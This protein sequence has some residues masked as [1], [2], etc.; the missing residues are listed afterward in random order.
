M[1]IRL[2][3]L[4]LIFL[5]ASISKSFATFVK[6]NG[7]F[8]DYGLSSVY[9]G[10]YVIENSTDLETFRDL[11]DNSETMRSANV[12]LLADIVLNER[13]LDTNGDLRSDYE[14][15]GLQEWIS[16]SQFSGVF[17]GNGHSISGI[18]MNN[19]SDSYGF[20]SK[21]LNAIVKDLTLLDCFVSGGTYV[22]GFAGVATGSTI[23]DSFITGR[24]QGNMNVGGFVGVLESFSENLSNTTSINR[25]VNYATISATKYVGGLS[26]YARNTNLMISQCVN[27]G[28]VYGEYVG[29]L[30]GSVSAYNGETYHVLIEDSRNKGAIQ[31]VSYA[32]GILGL[33]ESVTVSVKRCLNSGK[34]DNNFISG[35]IVGRSGDILIEECCN[36]GDISTSEHAAGIIGRSESNV[37]LKNN[38]N[39]GT[40]LGERVICGIGELSDNCSMLSCI[41]VGFVYAQSIVAPLSWSSLDAS[42]TIENNYYDSNIYSLYDDHGVGISTE[43]L[44]SG[45]LMNLDELIWVKGNSLIESNI[46]S[47]DNVFGYTINGRY[48]RLIWMQEH[49]IAKKMMY[50][51]GN[52]QPDW[53][54]YI[55]IY[56]LSE[57]N[58]IK[59]NTSAN[60]VVMQNINDIGA[61]EPIQ[62]FSGKF[63]GNNKCISGF[64]IDFPNVDSVGVFKSIATTG[65][66][67]NVVLKQGIIQGRYNVGGICGAT[68]GI[69]RNCKNYATVKG[70][71]NVGGICG[72][73]EAGEII[74]CYNEGLVSALS[75]WSAGICGYGE[76]I[77]TLVKNCSNKGTIDSGRGCD[78]GICGAGSM[79]IESCYNMGMIKSTGYHNGGIVGWATGNPVRFCINVGEVTGVANLGAI[80]GEGIVEHC[81]Y[82]S[83]KCTVKGSNNIDLLGYVE[84]RKTKELCNEMILNDLFSSDWAIMPFEVK[85]LK[86]YMYYPY[87]KIFGEESAELG[88]ILP[89]SPVFFNFNEGGTTDSIITYY[90]EGE[91]ALLP[92]NVTKKGCSFNG[93][94]D[95]SSYTSSKYTEIPVSSVGSR[96][97]YAQWIVNTYTVDLIT[98]DGF[99]NSGNVI[100]YSYG[101]GATLPVDVTKAGYDFAGWYEEEDC[102]GERVYSIA[103]DDVGNRIFYAKWV[104]KKYAITFYT[105]GGS[106]LDEKVTEY[107]Y[108]MEI[109]LPK[110]LRLEG[111]TFKGWYSNSYFDGLPVTEIEAGSL[112]DKQFW[113]RWVINKYEV[114]VIAGN[115]V[116]EGTGIFEYKS[117]VSLKAVANEG[118]EFVNW[119][120]G[121]TDSKIQLVVTK[122]TMVTANFRE[123]EKVLAV[124]KLVFPILKTSRKVDPIDLSELFQSSEDGDMIFTA[125]SSTPNIVS[126]AVSEQKLFLTVYEYEGE[127]EITVTATLANGEKKSLQ[128]KATVEFACNILVSETITNVSCYG[129]ND[130]KIAL[131]IVNA[132]EP[133]S[134]QWIGLEEFNDTLYSIKAGNYIV[135]I[136]DAEGCMYQ[137][138]YN[139]LQPQEIEINTII[140]NPT[141]GNSDGSIITSISGGTSFT[142]IWN[143]DTTTRSLVNV[144]SGEY[145]LV[146]VNNETGCKAETSV[147]LSEPDAP[148]VKISDVIETACNESNGAVI[149]SG[150][151]NLI[152]KWNNGR[153]TKNLLNVPAGDYTLVVTDENNC[154]DTIDV[155]VPSIALKQPEISL[156]TVS[157]ESGKNLVVWLKENTDLIDYYTIYRETEGKDIYEMV[158]RVPYSE[159]SV[160]ED[161]DADPNIRAWRYKMTATDVCGTE[162]EMSAHHKTIH[163]RKNMGMNNT[164][165]LEWDEYEGFDFSSFVIY[166][167]YKVGTMSML[168]T[169]ATLPSNVT[170][171]TDL[172]PVKRTTGYY[173]GIVLPTVINPKTQFMKSESG[174]FVMA[175]SNIAEVEND[176][177]TGVKNVENQMFVF[178]IDHSIYVK[179]AEG[180]DITIYDNNG[181]SIT[182]TQTNNTL[183]MMQ[184]DVRLDGIY[185]VKVGNESFAVLV[186]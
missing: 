40:I 13:V 72:R 118:Y 22:G 167:E 67:M 29:G 147:V 85:D 68:M 1:K 55:P 92:T 115:G 11:V 142:Y 81:Y 179:N 144:A 38:I 89:C 8:E 184:Y 105:S 160:Y 152:Y 83:E 117:I 148:V 62:D 139:V 76:S 111:Y 54:T 97:F 100:S 20:F 35:G 17:D 63:S 174:P 79:R 141:C 183:N 3:L 39:S 164:Y 171:I 154:K 15:V 103:M 140:T 14:S 122:D 58:R 169:I 156:V 82:D 165:N 107:S 45:F 9:D 88:V 161:L 52:D 129:E 44:C 36:T 163:L 132:S 136:E 101:Y 49:P 143:N 108:G 34:I 159:L 130:G 47:D 61:W 27:Y 75:G 84:G 119:G 127:S 137:K 60:Y 123:K 150:S 28:D 99:I 66:V 151:D 51:F 116:V 69:I 91:T 166:R 30:L 94:Y 133:Y 16:I 120:N 41:N 106:I 185:F 10:Y 172:E 7:N 121:S 124:G 73:I 145:N 128:A 180:N 93:W 177:I 95:N 149:I 112:G 24:I 173:V 56:T 157:Q 19:T 155:T 86:K 37:V 134:L 59:E 87:L 158:D 113:A 110:N 182:Q 181:R 23:E 176:E 48:P 2:F 25:C 90:V 109:S 135:S 170:A 12:V 53:E 104:A 126:V 6:I 98:N 78:G 18:Y 77:Y 186:K 80:A 4:M 64:S 153:A 162:T 71:Q 5:L 131:C 168:D 146:V 138:M 57:L 96:T 46:I 31:S 175:I 21:L 102:S 43:N 74:G 178:A 125:T 65:L 70:S 32:G 26:G 114:S 50:N 42:Q 33:I